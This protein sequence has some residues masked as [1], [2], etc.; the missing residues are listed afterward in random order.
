MENITVTGDFGRKPV[1]TFDSTEP[2]PEL[3]VEVLHE[4]EGQVVEAGDEIHCHYL[5]Q[6]WNGKVFDNSYDRGG[7]LTFQIGVGMVIRGWDEGLVGHRVGSRVLLSIPSEYGYGQRG[8][9]QAGIRG[10]DTLVFVTDIL[11]VA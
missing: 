10:G 6:V 1:L 8:V 7:A 3:L 2:S 9:P 4:G 5:G 11:G